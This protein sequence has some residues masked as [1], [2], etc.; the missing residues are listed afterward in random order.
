MI[1][2]GMAGLFIEYLIRKNYG[3]GSVRRFRVPSID[4]TAQDSSSNLSLV[5]KARSLEGR[6]LLLKQLPIEVDDSLNIWDG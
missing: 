3:A 4:G 1:V 2:A 6:F 5:G